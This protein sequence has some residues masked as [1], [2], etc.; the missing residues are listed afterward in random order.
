MLGEKS[1][2]YVR[3]KI[4]KFRQLFYII[5]I[6][7]KNVRCEPNFTGVRCEISVPGQQNPYTNLPTIIPLPDTTTGNGTKDQTLQPAT[8]TQQGREAQITLSPRCNFTIRLENDGFFAARLKV[9]YSLDGIVQ[10]L[11]TSH[12]LPFIGQTAEFTIPYYATDIVVYA[13]RLVLYWIQTFEDTGINTLTRCTKCYKLW[14]VVG[15]PHWDYLL[16]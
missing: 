7:L 4:N 8:S 10:P 16:C 1:S 3:N 9:Q 5:N 14:G 11:L 15:D 6:S 12:G 13:E 2:S